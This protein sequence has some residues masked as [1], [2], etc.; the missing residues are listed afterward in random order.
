MRPDDLSR[1]R[2]LPEQRELLG[3]LAGS[4]LGARFQVAGGTAI[5]AFYLHHRESEDL[6]LFSPDAV[7]LQSV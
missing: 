4:E 7:P 2:L 5:A 3:A 1:A 6:D